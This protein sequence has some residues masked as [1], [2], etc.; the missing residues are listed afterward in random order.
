MITVPTTKIKNTK[1]K[2][3]KIEDTKSFSGC[4][5]HL[6]KAAFSSIPV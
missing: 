3:M 4:R 6:M 2:V 5:N 1:I